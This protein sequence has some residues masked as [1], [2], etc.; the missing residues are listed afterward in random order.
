M[1]HECLPYTPNENESARHLVARQVRAWR[2]QFHWSQEALAE[3][4]GL[5]R[6]YIG[7][8]ERAEVSVGVDTLGRIA[9]A[10]GVGLPE[11]LDARPRLEV[12]EGIGL[13]NPQ[14]A[15]W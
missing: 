12:R 4:A 6:T 5:H 13:N 15:A 3:A 9:L 14:V 1:S 10:F 8:I 11:L 7:S 2:H